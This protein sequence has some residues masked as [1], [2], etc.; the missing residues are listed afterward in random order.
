[1]HQAVGYSHLTRTST[2]SV[3]I[4]IPSRYSA[5]STHR[6]VS[7]TD[8]AGRPINERPSRLRRGPGPAGRICKHTYESSCV[9]APYSSAVHAP[10]KDVC[11]EHTTVEF[12]TKLTTTLQITWAEF[13]QKDWTVHRTEPAWL[14]TPM[15]S[16]A[17]GNGVRYVPSRRVT[18]TRRLL[19]TARAV[20]HID[21]A[22]SAPRTAMPGVGRCA[23]DMAHVD[24]MPKPQI[25][26]FHGI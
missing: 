26:H 1:V 10:K 6:T 13:F 17:H 3:L 16:I 2:S 8:S 20:R 18:A 23:D 22:R 24:R 11:P 19:Q 4:N 25:G 12:Y 9:V 14:S 5:W 7:L 21:P 15:P